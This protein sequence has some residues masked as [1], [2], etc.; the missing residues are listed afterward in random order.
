MYHR[1]EDLSHK[2]G[3]SHYEEVSAHDAGGVDGAGSPGHAAGGCAVPSPL[4]QKQVRPNRRQVSP[5]TLG[6]SW[7][8]ARC[9]AV[10][11]LPSGSWGLN[12]APRRCGVFDPAR[13]ERKD[14]AL[15]RQS[16]ILDELLGRGG[17]MK[18]RP[19]HLLTFLYA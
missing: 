14:V 6:R 7:R 15:V 9:G 13:L 11:R 17:E 12:F 4:E 1:L 19:V 16:L 2:Q 10:T 18:R 5:E 8:K 3:D